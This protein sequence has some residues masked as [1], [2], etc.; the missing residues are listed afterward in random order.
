[1]FRLASDEYLHTPIVCVN[2]RTPKRIDGSNQA[3]PSSTSGWCI[4]V[5]AMSIY[6]GRWPFVGCSNI[7]VEGTSEN[8]EV[9]NADSDIRHWLKTVQRPSITPTCGRQLVG[10]CVGRWM[11]AW[12]NGWVR[13]WEGGKLNVWGVWIN[14]VG[15]WMCQWVIEWVCDWTDCWVTEWVQLNVWVTE[16]VTEWKGGYWVSLGS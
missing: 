8:W 3:T 10:D 11:D 12:L 14:W 16:C 13:E 6:P 2:P 1:M 5:W 4:D 9:M 7:L 15:D